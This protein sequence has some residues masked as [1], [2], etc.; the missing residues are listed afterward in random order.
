M[1]EGGGRGEDCSSNLASASQP[2]WETTPNSVFFIQLPENMQ[3]Y[4]YLQTERPLPAQRC[5]TLPI[6][7]LLYMERAPGTQVQRWEVWLICHLCWWRWSCSTVI[8][9]NS[10]KSEVLPWEQP[11][12]WGGETAYKI[13]QDGF[14]YRFH[15]K[16]TP[17]NK[18]L[19][20]L[21]MS[22]H[23]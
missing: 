21:F 8:S 12:K 13:K 3:Q 15:K 16:R 20:P 7:V 18:E 19:E 10:G 22:R 9:D 5:Y 4:R 14:L 6:R 2:K 23:G 1:V 17:Y 11:A